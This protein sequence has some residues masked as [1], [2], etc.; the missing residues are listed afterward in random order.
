MG[1]TLQGVM[2]RHRG[3]SILAAVL[4]FSF[5]FAFDV[6]RDGRAAEPISLGPLPEGAVSIIGT[7]GRA[8]LSELGDDYGKLLL[9]TGYLRQNDSKALVVSDSPKFRGFYWWRGANST[10][11]AAKSAADG[12]AKAYEAP[13]VLFAEG[14]NP[15]AD[16]EKYFTARTDFLYLGEDRTR[17]VLGSENAP[18]AIVAFFSHTC[19]HCAVFMEKSFPKLK[20]DYIDKGLVRLIARD[21]VRGNYDFLPAKMVRCTDAARFYEAMETVSRTRKDWIVDEKKNQVDGGKLRSVLTS[22][23]KSPADFDVCVK[24]RGLDAQL[25]AERAEAERLFSV[26]EAPSFSV[27]GVVHHDTFNW[28]TW[29]NI[30][31]A[32]LERKRG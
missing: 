13:C 12:C 25:A 32:H 23:V 5:V 30:L 11:E 10:N 26:F 17:V 2:Q 7:A 4:L 15:K 20:K 28:D 16:P 14:S 22:F 6:P 31:K 21:Y 19:P 18:I 3:V 1:G 8:N 27:N 9:P 29:E 24:N